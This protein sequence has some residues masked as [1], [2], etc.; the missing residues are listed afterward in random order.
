MGICYKDS[1]LLCG[2]VEQQDYCDEGTWVPPFIIAVSGHPQRTCAYYPYKVKIG[3]CGSKDD[4]S[5]GMCSNLASRCDDPSSFV[6][7]DP[8]CSIT[9]DGSYTGDEA[10]QELKISSYWG[11]ERYPFSQWTTYGSCND[12]CVWSPDDC[13]EG[14]VYNNNNLAC[15]ANKVSIGACFSGYAYCVVSKD[16]CRTLEGRVEPY[17]SHQE[18]LDKFDANCYLADLGRVVS[19]ATPTPTSSPVVTQN[20]VSSPTINPT[21]NPTGTTPIVS[22]SSDSDTLPVENSESKSIELSEGAIIGICVGC[23]A[24][25][26]IVTL[27]ARKRKTKRARKPPCPSLTITMGAEV[28]HI[29]H[30]LIKHTGSRNPVSR[31]TGAKVM[32]SPEDAH[33]E[34]QSYEARIR[35]EGIDTA[36]P[37]YAA[38]RSDCSSYQNSGALAMGVFEESTTQ[39]PLER[40]SNDLNAGEMSGVITTDSGY[41]L[42]YKAHPWESDED[43]SVLED[44]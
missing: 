26:F 10:E 7:R 2:V 24:L 14:E 5:P 18:V 35:S 38:E 22:A 15:T 6:S 12:R 42:V 29:A 17:L 16:N 19:P 9:H 32:L 39:K 34:L 30:L 27:A 31:R 44:E 21:G 28:Q 43:V 20:L 4:G 37:K 3:R 36:F 25:A 1:E 11:N 8:T 41:H 23:I 33:A 13:V 40:A